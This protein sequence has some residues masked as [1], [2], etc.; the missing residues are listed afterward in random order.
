MGG[1]MPWSFKTAAEVAKHLE[2]QRLLAER[3]RDGSK[4]R[5]DYWFYQ[6]Q[7]TAFESAVECVEAIINNADS[8]D[9][10]Q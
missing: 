3:R 7:M 10:E 4:D 9:E 5:K 2:E 1:A 6:G 8:D